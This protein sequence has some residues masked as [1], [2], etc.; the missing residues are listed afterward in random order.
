MAKKQKDLV[1][2]KWLKFMFRI[3]KHDV[4][5]ISIL[6]LLFILKIRNADNKLLY[7]KRILKVK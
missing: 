2:I 3:P 7:L 4:K 1:E 6:I 5:K